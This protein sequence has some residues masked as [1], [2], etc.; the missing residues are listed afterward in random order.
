MQDYANRYPEETREVDVS[1]EASAEYR[2]MLEALTSDGLPRFEARF[3]ALLN[4]NTIRDIAGFHARLRREE[5]EIRERI[6][7][8]NRSLRQIDYNPGRY[9][10]LEDETDD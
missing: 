7:I 6:E 2:Q 9:I 5:D 1:P 3:K 10:V 4:E 8:I